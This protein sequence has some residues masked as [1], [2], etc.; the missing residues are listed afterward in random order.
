MWRVRALCAILRLAVICRAWRPGK[1]SRYIDWRWETV[2]GRGKL[3]NSKAMVHAGLG[4]GRWAS[5]MRRR[6]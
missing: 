3:P 4:F 1:R 5:M 2:F 6:Q